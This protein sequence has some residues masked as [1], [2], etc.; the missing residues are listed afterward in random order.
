VRESGA[1][2]NM[3]DPALLLMMMMQFLQNPQ[4]I[5]QVV[6]ATTNVCAEKRPVICAN[7]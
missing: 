4:K 3:A 1:A 6:V 2:A 5:S 7:V